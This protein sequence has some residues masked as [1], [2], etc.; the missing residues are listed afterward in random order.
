MCLSL[1][2][3]LKGKISKTTVV[4]ARRGSEMNGTTI[5]I[6]VIVAVVLVVVVAAII[7]ALRKRREQQARQEEARQEYGSEYERTVEEKGSEKA[8][9]KDLRERQ[10]KVESE[11][12]PLSD[13]SSRKYAEQWEE[14]ERT[15]VDEPAAALDGADRVVADILSERNFPT[16]S[17]EE[18]SKSLGV[19]HSDIVGEFREA[20]RV[21]QEATG[22]S[23]P[24]NDGDSGN[25]SEEDSNGDS[26]GADLEK[27]RQAIQEYRSVYERLT[28]E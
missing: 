9:E 12:Q 27:M 24:S 23:N 13:E 18:A 19:V 1:H 5:A 14:I 3:V 21:H 11:I 7:L 6:I 17:R 28:K 4:Q 2:Y 8:A 26:G 22:P 20:Q 10:E 16:D 15:F 25:S